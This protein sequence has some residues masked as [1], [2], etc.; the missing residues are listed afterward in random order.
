MGCACLL[1]ALV[2]SGFA[3]RVH[4]TQLLVVGAVYINTEIPCNVSMGGSCTEVALAV[5]L[6]STQGDL[7]AG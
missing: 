6:V 2:I 3:G 4:N 7:P 1:V 5:A